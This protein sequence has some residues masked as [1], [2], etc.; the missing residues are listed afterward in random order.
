MQR[1]LISKKFRVKNN[2]PEMKYTIQ[3]A[4]EEEASSWLNALPLSKHGFDL[5]TTEFR[6]GI[7]L[8]YTSEATDIPALCPH[9]IEV[10]LTHALHCARGGY[11]RLRH[12][13]IRDVFADL[14]DDV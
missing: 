6:D 13:E 7:A 5:T 2:L 3:L 11:S 10:S 9:G 12:N 14:I 4:S 1:E 8:R